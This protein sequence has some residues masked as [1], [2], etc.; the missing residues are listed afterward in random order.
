M[1]R[2]LKVGVVGLGDICDVYIKNLQRYP[3]QVQVLACAARG[4]DT[5]RAKAEQHGIPRPYAD[6]AAL[7]ADAEVDLVL[8]LTPPKAH[9]A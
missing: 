4:I 9:A 6:A 5:A 8:N 7:L 1:S 2:P 3:E